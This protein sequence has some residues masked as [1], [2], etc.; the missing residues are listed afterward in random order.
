MDVPQVFKTKRCCFYR[1]SYHDK[2]VVIRYTTEASHMVSPMPMK[3]N[4]SML[5]VLFLSVPMCLRGAEKESKI[6][7]PCLLGSIFF[8]CEA[9][10]VVTAV[11]NVFFSCISLFFYFCCEKLNT[12]SIRFRFFSLHCFFRFATNTTTVFFCCFF[13]PLCLCI[14]SDIHILLNFVSFTIFFVI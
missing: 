2:A 13:R 3:K 12:F 11:L 10:A 1:G 6:H 9:E 14:Q 8:F 7:L 5:Y 4:G